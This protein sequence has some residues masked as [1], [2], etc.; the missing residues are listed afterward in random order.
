[1]K[2]VTDDN[3]HRAPLWERGFGAT[4][5]NYKVCVRIPTA[6]R[7]LPAPWVLAVLVGMAYCPLAL[8]SETQD[9][10]SET[11]LSLPAVPLALMLRYARPAVPGTCL[12]AVH[13]HTGLVQ[14]VRGGG[15]MEWWLCLGYSS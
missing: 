7:S 3:T 6:G 10:T 5:P 14:M 4:H 2:G 13:P 15:V 11:S 1:M 12:S 8:A 9:A